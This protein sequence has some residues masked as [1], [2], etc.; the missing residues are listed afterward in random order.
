LFGVPLLR[1]HLSHQ[2]N[3]IKGDQVKIISGKACELSPALYNSLASFR[4]KVFVERLG[5]KLNT[6]IGY[7]QDQ[8]DHDDTLHVV[9]RDECGAILGCG[10]L[11]P[12]T[13]SYLLE[14]VFPELLNGLPVPRSDKVWEL[15]RFAA[16]EVE[17]GAR[18]AG[19]HRYVAE[20]LLL[21]AL[22]CC[23]DHQVT[24]LLAVSTLPVERLMQRAGVDVHRIGPPQR[25]DG[26]MVLGFVIGVNDRSIDA[27]MA[28]EAAA[29]QHVDM[30]S[31]PR[32]RTSDGVVLAEL[33]K[34][35]RKMLVS[36]TCRS[37][38]CIAA[39]RQYAVSV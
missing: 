8:F 19:V 6:D 10:R 30:V 37:S 38:A 34:I 23:A 39:F 27:L 14:S 32:C 36:H 29:Q 1:N 31:H 20:R 7:E 17:N 16:M 13:D 33:H 5:W 11:L 24:H 3:C 18:S 21:K 25:I 12:T 22:Q 28:F 35:E 4:Y 15:S 9:A 26:Q 2:I